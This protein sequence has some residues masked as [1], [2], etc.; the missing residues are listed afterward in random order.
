MLA[1]DVT[2]KMN[3][4]EELV[5]GPRDKNGNEVEAGNKVMYNGEQ[6]TVDHV[7]GDGRLAMV[8]VDREAPEDAPGGF[9]VEWPHFTEKVS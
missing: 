1:K 9:E 7:R 2:E 5:F 8:P 6:Y 3:Q 4:T